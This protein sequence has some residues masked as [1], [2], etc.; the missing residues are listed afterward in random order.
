MFPPPLCN[1]FTPLYFACRNSLVNGVCLTFKDRFS[2][3]FLRL[4]EPAGVLVFS[5]APFVPLLSSRAPAALLFS[6]KM[7]FSS[8]RHPDQFGRSFLDAFSMFH[9][10]YQLQCAL[11][12]GTVMTPMQE[13]PYAYFKS[14]LFGVSSLCLFGS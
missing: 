5:L 11:W 14:S 6:S 10:P 3:I 8:V 4:F 13:D 9:S 1:A 7:K 12:S 2:T